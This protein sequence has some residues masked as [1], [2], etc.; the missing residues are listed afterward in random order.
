MR[1]VRCVVAV[2]LLAAGG[3][4]GATDLQSFRA[5]AHANSAASHAAT[6]GSTIP[7]SSGVALL[8]TSLLGFAGVIRKRFV[9]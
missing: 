5:G 2:I 1:L 6:R 8:G 9:D 7:E 3:S 4:A